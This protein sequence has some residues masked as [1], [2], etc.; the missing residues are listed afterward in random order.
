MTKKFLEMFFNIPED[1][2]K[3]SGKDILDDLTDEQMHGLETNRK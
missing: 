1:R 3:N 2:S